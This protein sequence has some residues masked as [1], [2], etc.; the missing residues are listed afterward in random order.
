MAKEGSIR[1]MSDS[2]VERLPD[3]ASSNRPQWEVFPALASMAKI[4]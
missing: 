4:S 2:Q 1:T 3:Q